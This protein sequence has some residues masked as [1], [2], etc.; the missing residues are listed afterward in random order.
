MSFPFYANVTITDHGSPTTWSQD[1][2]T[3]CVDRTF[4]SL[5]RIV[6]YSPWVVT[7]SHGYR[8]LDVS[9]PVLY[10]RSVP[11]WDLIPTS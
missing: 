11:L 9:F 2:S 5:S 10:Y 3:P 6:T 1:T 4:Q 8:S 7:S